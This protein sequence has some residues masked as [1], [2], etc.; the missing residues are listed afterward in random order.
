MKRITR[1]RLFAAAFLVVPICFSSRFA[2]ANT[3]TFFLARM[4]VAWSSSSWL[5]PPKMD[6]VGCAASFCSEAL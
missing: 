2:L 5:E 4:K 1:R 3:S 6:S